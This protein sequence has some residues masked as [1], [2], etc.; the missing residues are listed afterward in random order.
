MPAHSKAQR[1]AMAIAEHHPEESYY[2]SMTKMKHSDLHDFAS[3][4]EKGLPQK[5][6]KKRS[7]K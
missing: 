3:T 1:R 2:P 5:K 7:S 4:K 6:G